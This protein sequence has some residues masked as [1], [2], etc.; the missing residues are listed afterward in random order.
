MELDKIIELVEP[1][2]PYYAS[3]QPVTSEALE[4]YMQTNSAL[5]LALLSVTISWIS[6]SISFTLF[7]RK[8][9]LFITH[10]QRFFRGTHGGFYIL[11]MSLPQ[12]IRKRQVSL[13]NRRGIFSVIRNCQ[14]SS[15]MSQSCHLPQQQ[16]VPGTTLLY[17]DVAH[18][19]L[20]PM[21]NHPK[22]TNFHLLFC[23]T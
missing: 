8:W 20:T 12:M 6:F 23:V 18:T 10:P 21:L 11:L 5:C 7:R 9:K 15:R 17:P 3:N 4:G 22:T 1:I 19:Y 16:H 13:L 14:R 2:S